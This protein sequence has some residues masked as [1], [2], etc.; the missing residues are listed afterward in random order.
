[1]ILGVKK[2]QMLVRSYED[3]TVKVV[4]DEGPPI[5]YKV[6]GPADHS[7]T[8]LFFRDYQGFVGRMLKAKKVKISVPF[9][10]QGNVV[11]E[12]NVSDFDSDRYLD[13]K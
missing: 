5:S 7:T 1:L 8:S 2:G 12:F 9:Y 11:F 13:K 6:T 3:A 10:Q 4:F